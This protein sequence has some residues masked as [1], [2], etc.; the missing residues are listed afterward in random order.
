MINHVDILQHTEY[1]NQMITNLGIYK[2]HPTHS[3]HISQ[4]ISKTKAAQM[5]NVAEKDYL[6]ST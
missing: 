6:Q 4:S 3:N 5:F 1:K 2:Q